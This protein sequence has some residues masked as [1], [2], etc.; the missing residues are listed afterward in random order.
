MDPQDILPLSTSML[1]MLTSGYLSAPFSKPRQIPTEE[2][3]LRYTM[4]GHVRQTIFYIASSNID[5]TYVWVTGLRFYFERNLDCQCVEDVW[6]LKIATSA[7]ATAASTGASTEMP[8][9]DKQIV[10]D[11]ISH[12]IVN[13]SSLTSWIWVGSI[14]ICHSTP[15]SDSSHLSQDLKTTSFLRS[16]LP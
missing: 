10:C 6:V 3:S 15:S 4:W 7:T 5:N 2:K 9:N 16:H 1:L 13:M 14:K 12:S 11:A 8:N